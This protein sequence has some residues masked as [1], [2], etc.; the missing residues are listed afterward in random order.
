[1]S[2]WLAFWRLY[3]FQKRIYVGEYWCFP[4][5]LTTTTRFA[6]TQKRLTL[7]HCFSFLYNAVATY[8]LRSLKLKTYMLT[9]KIN[10][11]RCL[12]IIIYIFQN[13]LKKVWH[14]HLKP[15]AISKL[16]GFIN[17]IF[18]ILGSAVF[19]KTIFLILYW[20]LK[21]L[22]K[23]LKNSNMSTVISFVFVYIHYLQRIFPRSSSIFKECRITET[24]I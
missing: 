16:A 7:C 1:M 11:L 22:Q 23:N 12:E 4:C 14:S 3:Y 5:R 18:A 19:L 24:Y 9:K 13:Q 8:N 21:V 15:T 20:C 6:T 2:V 10:L 17:W